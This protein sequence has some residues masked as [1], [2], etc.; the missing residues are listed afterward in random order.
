MLRRMLSTDS[1]FLFS[2]REL[3]APGRASASFSLLLPLSAA[4]TFSGLNATLPLLFSA[5]SCAAAA[6]P[7]S[8]SPA[9]IRLAIILIFIY[10][11][12]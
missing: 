8:A 3:N 2:S 10:P 4:E 12:K 7:Y 6:C 11:Q 5:C 1:R 9:P